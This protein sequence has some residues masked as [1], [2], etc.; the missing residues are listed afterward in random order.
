MPKLTLYVLEDNQGWDGY[1]FIGVYT[2]GR[3]ALNAAKRA[4]IASPFVTRIVVNGKPTDGGNVVY[5]HLK[6][7]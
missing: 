4:N 7:F 6:G 5:P 2:T 3:R 1:Q